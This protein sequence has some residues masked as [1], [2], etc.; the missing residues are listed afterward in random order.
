M[1][2]SVIAACVLR[3][4]IGS[5]MDTCGF[6]QLTLL[7]MLNTHSNTHSQNA[8]I[9]LASR[10]YIDDA[11]EAS[12]AQEKQQREAGKHGHTSSDC[13]SRRLASSLPGSATQPMSSTMM[14]QTAA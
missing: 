9:A 11:M 6:K 7:R 10:Q 2:D 14:M 4:Y 13:K 1:R 12:S 5:A 8:M 3:Q